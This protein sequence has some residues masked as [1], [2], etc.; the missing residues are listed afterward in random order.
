MTNICINCIHKD[1][2][3]KYRLN[4]VSA[5]EGTCNNYY[6]MPKKG[7]WINKEIYDECPFCLAGYMKSICEK[8]LDHNKMNFCFNCGANMKED[9]EN[10]Q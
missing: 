4:Y 7:K 1:V 9:K 6:E 3:Y 2:C 5:R 8:T 10:E